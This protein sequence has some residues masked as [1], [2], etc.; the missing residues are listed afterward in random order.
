VRRLALNLLTVS[1]TLALLGL[2]TLPAWS[3]RSPSH[4]GAQG[5]PSG[6]LF[7]VYL[8]PW[9][10]DEWSD[11]VGVRPN[12]V[13]KFEAFWRRR[14]PERFLRQV[15]RDGVPAA[16]I[17]WEPWRPVPARLGWRRQAQKQPR[18]SNRAIAAGAQ[19]HYIARFARSV[20]SFDGIV[21]LRYAHEM[22]GFWYPW[23]ADAAAYV[24]AWR[25]V[26]RLFRAE[27]ADNVRFVWSVNLNLYESRSKWLRH[28]QRY[29]PGGRYVD[30][31]GSTMIN[32]GATKQYTVARFEP[33]LRRLHGAFRKPV[34]LAETNTELAGHLRW[35]RDLGAML[36]RAPWIRALVWSQLPSRGAVQAADET[37]DLG[38]DVARDVKA[39][40]RLRE[41]ASD[42]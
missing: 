42:G 2:L 33:A 5:V 25:R 10:V 37:G 41:V 15:E 12:L 3:V 6:R 11:A 32:F 7:G 39:A 35:L 30:A 31:V 19:D 34:V 14:T 24:R 26:V 28:A 9:H 18:F 29:W 13:A 27:G 40:A 22:N 23:S 20:A 4:A 21:Y 36:E 16:L 1:A 17:S 8:D 38:W